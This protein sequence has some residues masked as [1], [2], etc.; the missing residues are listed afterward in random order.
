M[1]IGQNDLL[2]SKTKLWLFIKFSKEQI[3]KMALDEIF[4]KF[5]LT[6]W[7]LKFMFVTC[8]F[9]GKVGGELLEVLSPCHLCPHRHDDCHDNSRGTIPQLL[10]WL[11]GVHRCPLLLQYLHFSC[12]GKL[13]LTVLDD[14]AKDGWL[15]V[16]RPFQEYFI[17]IKWMKM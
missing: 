3:V 6:E 11:K 12:R 14:F 13:V 2:I 7:Q 1:N 17:H 10:L 16:L 9:S 15:G 4:Q 5:A 8:L